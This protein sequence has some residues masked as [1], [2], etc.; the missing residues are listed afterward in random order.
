MSS[1]TESSFALYQT[2]AVKLER[3][4]PQRFYH[5]VFGLVSEVGELA[6]LCKKAQTSGR[7]ITRAKWLE[8]LGDVLWYVA[9]A[10]DSL[11]GVMGETLPE[12]QPVTEYSR[13]PSSVFSAIFLLAGPVGDLAATCGRR[14][15]NVRMAMLF[16]ALCLGTII[17][18]VTWALNAADL[19]VEQAMRTNLE[20][21]HRRRDWGKDPAE[22]ARIF[23]SFV[24][25]VKVE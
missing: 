5:A 22:E 19:T 17:H 18:Y 6:D 24:G 3:L 20:K 9:L 1:A 8:E 14:E 15:D 21:L 16:S 12:A 23:A 2:E 11:G 13:R 4:C 10:Y 7:P 25:T